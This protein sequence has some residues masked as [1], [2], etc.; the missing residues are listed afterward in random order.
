MTATVHGL[1]LLALE[2]DPDVAAVSVDAVIKA[3]GVEQQAEETT[4]LENV[5]VASLGLSETRYDGDKVGIA[6][7]DSGLEKRRRSLRRPCRSVL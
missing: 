5:L 3:G 4:G 7:I 1:D 2:A 6:V